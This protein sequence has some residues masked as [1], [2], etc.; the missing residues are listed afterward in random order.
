VVQLH[1]QQQDSRAPAACSDSDEPRYLRDRCL[2]DMSASPAKTPNGASA[3]VV[4]KK[5]AA[6]IFNPK[7]KAPVRKPLPA[8]TFTAAG[9][10]PVNGTRVAPPPPRPNGAPV[11]ARP[12]DEDDPSTYEEF[13]VTISKSALMRN[14]HYHGIRLKAPTDDAG[15]TAIVNPFNENEF[16][17]P[18]RLYRRR[19]QDKPETAE[20]SDAASGL[21]DKEREQREIKKAERQAER[22]ANKALI[23]PTGESGKKQQKKK[24]QKK[25]EDVFYDENNP[26]HQARSK[27]RYEEAR[28]WHLEDFDNKNR[29]VG[30]Y[31]EPLARKHV[32][33]EVSN[34]GFNMVPVEK[35]YRMVRVDK[36][37]TLD[38]QQVQKMMEGKHNAPRWLMGRPAAEV[39]KYAK[40]E[41]TAVKREQL[42]ARGSGKQKKEE[43]SD[44]EP[45]AKNEEYRADVDEIDF[46]FN[47]E[48]QDDDEG[49]VF[50]DANDDD[51]KDAER[52]VREEQR[53]ANLPDATV[54]NADDE[55]WINEE[56]LEQIAK[57]EERKRQKKMRKQ[58]KRKEARYEYD[59][60][61][62]GNEYESSSDSDSEEEREREEE[63]RKKKEEAA[64][65]AQVNGDKSGASTKGTNTP[66]GRIEK[67]PLKREADVSE[68]S[69]NESSRKKAKLNGST[70]SSSGARQLSRTFTV[71]QDTRQCVAN[72]SQ[73]TLPSAYLPATGPAATQTPRV[74]VAH[75]SSSRTA[76]PGHHA[77]RPQAHP[78]HHAA[79]RLPAVALKALHVHRTLPFR[80]RRRLR[81]PYHLT[82]SVL[83]SSSRCSALGWQGVMP[84]SYRW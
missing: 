56:R 66:T 33:L 51:A 16:T 13:P 79:A 44:D 18:V 76:L 68:A 34:A 15:K 21:D 27:L 78:T 43:D 32:M 12:A 2:A 67:K 46:E 59:S 17:R 10:V 84:T 26:R 75:A 25:V 57:E 81:L 4:R 19:P 58:L 41:A 72:S 20:Q 52:R 8:N 3:P 62:E 50:G 61:D 29:W 40:E 73:L 82:A 42:A 70:P 65:A 48:F 35:W 47:D 14:L 83:P 49:F 23:A 24:P 80:L 54:K 28:P 11:Q 9:Q 7:K 55:D 1:G 71:G 36:V 64:K 39:A 37:K 53:T 69:G 63:E 6:S 60:D 22:E 77:H 5:P 31:E 74:P 38:D 30:T 45:F